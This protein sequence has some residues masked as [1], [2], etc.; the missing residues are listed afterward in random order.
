MGIPKFKVK[1]DI[2]LYSLTNSYTKGNFS[3]TMLTFH[4]HTHTI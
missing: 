1:Q 3:I 4:K 2:S